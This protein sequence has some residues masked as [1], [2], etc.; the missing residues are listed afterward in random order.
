MGINEQ[1]PAM[2]NPWIAQHMAAEMDHTGGEYTRA[3][4]VQAV[5]GEYASGPAPMPCECGGTAFYRA[6]VGARKCPDCGA[7]YRGNGVRV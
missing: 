4:A 2:Q 7:L 3:K 1:E 6:T 5:R